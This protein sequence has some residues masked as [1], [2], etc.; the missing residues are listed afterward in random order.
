MPTEGERP[1]TRR[2]VTAVA[3]FGLAAAGV[4]SPFAAR[5]GRAAAQT[6]KGSGKPSLKA[7]LARLRVPPAWFGSVRVRYDIRTPWK[8][9]RLHI[10]K[11][12][13]GDAAQVREGIKTTYMYARKGDIGDGHELP[14]YLFLGGEYAWAVVQYERRLAS[15]PQGH[16]H[17]Y[18]SLASCYMH[19]GEYSK[20]ERILTVAL[21]RLPAPPWRIARKADVHSHLGDLYA[22]MKDVA[23]ARKHYTMAIQLYPTSTQPWGR[24]L[25]KKHAAKVRAKLDLL[26][27]ESMDLKRLRD[28]TYSGSSL[29]YKGDVRVAVT[30]RGGRIVDIKVNHKE[31]I[32]QNAA[33]II[34]RRIIAAQDLK[35]DCITGA[36]ATTDAV[37]AA[38]FDA[39]KKAGLKR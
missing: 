19:F 28:G 14:M 11:L 34:P 23:R 32:D 25:L 31:D 33:E 36:T 9:A 3:A 10:R 18:L 27:Y 2:A 30:L 7:A 37:T 5:P 22:E 17:E 1:V 26:E 16:T 29:G 12:L 24:H 38:T 39:L 13:A 20:A 35:V 21:A 6:P 15:K 4:I 8:A